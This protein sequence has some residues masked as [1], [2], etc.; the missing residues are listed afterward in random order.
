MIDQI[1]TPDHSRDTCN[2]HSADTTHALLDDACVVPGGPTHRHAPHKTHF[3]TLYTFTPCQIHCLLTGVCC[4]A[5]HLQQ[6]L[7]PAAVWLHLR[8]HCYAVTLPLMLPLHPACQLPD[9]WHAAPAESCAQSQQQ[10][11]QQQQQRL[12]PQAAK[13]LRT[14][15]SRVLH[16]HQLPQAYPASLM[17]LVVR[18][19]P[20]VQAP[21]QAAPQK[22]L[23]PLAYYQLTCGLRCL[24]GCPQCCQVP[25]VPLCLLLPEQAVRLTLV[26]LHLD[27]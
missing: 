6:G 10:R 24:G 17:V 12:V 8:F 5:Q 2:L 18:L 7:L 26:Q 14:R 3:T 25:G 16:P 21:S 19:L 27:R 1:I 11:Q 4:W 22:L 23:A 15:T 9:H 13:C 20:Q